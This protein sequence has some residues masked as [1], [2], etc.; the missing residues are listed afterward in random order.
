MNKTLVGCLGFIGD[1]ILPNY[2]GIIIYNKPIISY[3]YEPTRIQWKGLLWMDPM[4]TN[5]VV[6]KDS[7]LI[8]I[9]ISS[10]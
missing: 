4:L 6:L 7:L 2:I 1:E 9:H 3:P 5:Q 8:R 10:I